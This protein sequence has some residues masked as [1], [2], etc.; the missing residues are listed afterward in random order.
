MAKNDKLKEEIAES[1]HDDI[2]GIM[3]G[4]FGFAGLSAAI[5]FSVWQWQQNGPWQGLSAF[6]G[7]I[8]II[9]VGFL[10]VCS[11]ARRK[12]RSRKSL[13]EQLDNR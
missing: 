5:A 6:L 11:I 1:R 13:I 3:L 9:G 4:T 2:I 8:I 12:A 7:M 10:K